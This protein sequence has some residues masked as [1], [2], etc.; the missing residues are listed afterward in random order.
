MNPNSLAAIQPE[1]ISNESIL[2]AYQPKAGTVF[3]RNDLLLIPFSLF[4][5]GF[6]I[7][8]ESLATGF[9]R[10]QKTGNNAPAF[11]ALWGLGFVLVGQYLIWGRF[12]YAAWL[13]KRTHYAVTNRRLIVV[14]SGFNRRVCSAYIDTLP[15]IIKEG[16]SNGAGVLRFTPSQ[17]FWYG[18]QGWGMWNSMNVSDIPTFMDI[19]DVDFVYRMVSDLREK[20]RTP[21]MTTV[22]AGTF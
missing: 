19:D 12:V 11:F 9:G 5:G 3:H 20:A 21:S 7:F 8:W 14:Q 1:L 16:E 18:R 10:I 6:T 13:K 22:P 15:T 17:P 2:W 4:W